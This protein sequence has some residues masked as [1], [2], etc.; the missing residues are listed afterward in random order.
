[1][2]AAAERRFALDRRDE[3]G[4]SVRQHLESLEKRGKLTAA[5]QAELHGAQIPEE[6]LD[7]WDLFNEI[8]QTRG[9]SGFGPLPIS[10]LEI[11][12]WSELKQFPISPWE[13]DLLR[14]LDQ[15][16]LQANA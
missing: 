3:K 14:R 2:I 5:Q 6:T 15:A 7:I 11:K 13:F 12:A 16:Y 10:A 9:S 4:F 8:A 1:M